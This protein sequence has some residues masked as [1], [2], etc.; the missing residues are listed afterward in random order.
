[1]G[2]GDDVRFWVAK[3]VLRFRDRVTSVENQYLEGERMAKAVR[4]ADRE[5]LPAVCHDSAPSTN[6]SFFRLPPRT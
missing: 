4:G 5:A 3:S 1:M 6:D 2:S